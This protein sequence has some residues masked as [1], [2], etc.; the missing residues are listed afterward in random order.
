MYLVRLG[1]NG[2]NMAQHDKLATVAALQQLNHTDSTGT[3]NKLS[4]VSAQ[5]S[6]REICGRADVCI[7]H[8]PSV[9]EL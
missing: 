6:R 7:F 9:R 4:A 1:T 5:I 3:F 2:L 8:N